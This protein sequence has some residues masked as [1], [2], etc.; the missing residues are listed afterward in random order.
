M[1]SIR[2]EHKVKNPIAVWSM[3]VK[4]NHELPTCDIKVTP[5]VL[6]TIFSQISKKYVFGKEI[7][8]SGYEHYQCFVSLKTKTRNPRKL[9][10]SVIHKP[11][12][13]LFY[14]CPASDPTALS[15][16]CCKDGDIYRGPVSKADL[17]DSQIK[18]YSWQKAVVEKLQQN[19]DNFNHRKFI[20]VSDPSGC[21]G[22]T[23]LLRYISAH[24]DY[25]AALLPRCSVSSM[26][27]VVSDI[28]LAAESDT[29]PLVILIDLVRSDNLAQSAQILELFQFI[30]S[31]LNCW[32]SSGSHGKF[33]EVKRQ[34]GTVQVLLVSNLQPG[35]V[36]DYLSYDRFQTLRISDH[37]SL[38]I[39]KF[40]D[41]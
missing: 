33:K 30:E 37:M 9:L 36:H 16:Y 17:E 8:E 41:A 22:K 25:N 18:L 24:P 1:I 19:I 20:F 7:G 5:D 31:I 34:L 4:A 38:P 39:S 21:A 10:E 23:V 35:V 11:L 27:S 26:Y 32:I 40:L 14:V 3:T 29:R 6:H 12:L 13:G 15:T 2:N 28:F